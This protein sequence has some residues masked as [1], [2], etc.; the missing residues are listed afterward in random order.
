MISR[1]T[2]DCLKKQGD[3][4]NPVKLHSEVQIPD[5]QGWQHLLALI[6]EAASDGRREFDP[7][8]ELSE[9]ERVEVITLPRSIAKLRAVR[10]LILYETFLSRIPREIGDLRDLREFT[11]YKSWRLHWLPFELTRCKKLKKGTISIR[12]LYGNI[13]E[14]PPFPQLPVTGPE[15][16]R[17]AGR[18]AEGPIHCSVC[19]DACDPENPIQRWISLPIWRDVVPLLVH[20]CSYACVTR[21]P[22]PAPDQVDHP[23]QGGIQLQQPSPRY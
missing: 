7:F 12:S 4:W 14:R 15:L 5:S 18:T 9:E 11:P 23:H 21:L 8:S 16:W 10:H 17:I 22:K 19:N 13:K 2:C 6:D 20:A 3:R 1:P